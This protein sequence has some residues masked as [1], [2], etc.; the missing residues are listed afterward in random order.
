MATR[1]A[2]AAAGDAGGRLSH[3]QAEAPLPCTSKRTKLIERFVGELK[4]QFSGGQ[5]SAQRR[6]LPGIECGEIA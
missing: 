3:Y 4:G 2:W 1:G 5:L 6:R